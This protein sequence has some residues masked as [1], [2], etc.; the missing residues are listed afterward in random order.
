MSA[1]AVG[2]IALSAVS[3]AT[4]EA[5]PPAESQNQKIYVTVID[6]KGN[7]VTG[8]TK[9]DFIV[10][11]DKADQEVLGVQP[12]VDPASVVILTDRLGLNTTYTPPAVGDILKTFA[13][14]FRKA[15]PDSKVA[16]TTFDG[17]IIEVT[18]FTSAFAET[19][20]M[21]GRLST[22]TPEAVLFDGIATACQAMRSAPTDRKIVFT[23]LASY[24]P[25]HSTMQ[26]DRLGSILRLSGASLWVLE[27]RLAEGGNYNNPAR[28]QILDA[29]S[30]LS[31]GTREVVRSVTGAIA[32]SKR[33][34]QLILSQYVLTFG[35]GG[36]GS[37]TQQVVEVR[38]PG[39]RVLAPGWTTR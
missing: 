10:R 4:L 13:S 9:E 18:K 3:F 8:L 31:G 22:N 20:R 23:L 14:A 1:R 17:T 28:E 6:A 34:A 36:G 39:V 16:L 26:P 25:D 27:A 30:A 37:Q 7:P 38:R 33:F 5:R 21:L 12:A 15:N 2:L 29:G 19:D 11:L 35:P 32:T 24:R